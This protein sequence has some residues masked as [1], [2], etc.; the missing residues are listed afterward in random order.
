MTNAN[1]QVRQFPCY[2]QLM[3]DWLY[4]RFGTQRHGVKLLARAADV[5][6][7]TADNWLRGRA[8]P[9]GDNLLDLIASD[10]S[11][12]DALMQAAR[13]R[14]RH[15]FPTDRRTQRHLTAVTDAHYLS[16]RQVSDETSSGLRVGVHK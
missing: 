7:H 1:G 4:S 10:P 16:Q 9:Q 3:R 8:A 6:R 13:E 5:S 15:R 12:G 11:L 14:A 2:P